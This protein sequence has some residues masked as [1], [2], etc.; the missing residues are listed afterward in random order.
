MIDNIPLWCFI[1]AIALNAA[2][3]WI[4]LPSKSKDK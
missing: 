1:A 3:I 2:L 4:I